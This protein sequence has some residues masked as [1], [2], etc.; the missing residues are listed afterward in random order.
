MDKG[1]IVLTHFPFTDLS[2][3]KR[4]PALVVSAKE[5]EQG[6]VILAY[7]TTLIPLNLSDTDVLMNL[8]K[9]DYFK[10]GLKKES[11]INLDK[12][13][14]INRRII[15][16]ELGSLSPI[17]INEINLKLKIALGLE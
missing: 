6:D 9:P 13:V 7:I 16:G 11:I 3:I 12:F 5:S 8:L 14:T 17:S 1:T 10:S 4:R 2:T 15:T